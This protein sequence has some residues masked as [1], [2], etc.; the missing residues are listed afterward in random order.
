MVS[1]FQFNTRAPAVVEFYVKGVTLKGT[2]L[3]PH[4]DTEAPA[5]VCVVPTGSFLLVWC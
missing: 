5:E 2:V 4:L 1:L 3:V